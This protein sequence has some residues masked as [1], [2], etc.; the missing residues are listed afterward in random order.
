MCRRSITKSDPDEIRNGFVTELQETSDQLATALA[1]LRF[2]Q[3]AERASQLALDT[4]ITKRGKDI[5]QSDLSLVRITA[6][7]APQRTSELAR[8]NADLEDVC[9]SLR[10]TQFAVW[11]SA[12]ALAALHASLVAARADLKKLPT[13]IA[14]HERFIVMASYWV[15]A[16]N[17]DI[18]SYLM[19][20]VSGYVSERLA[21][22]L[23]ALAAGEVRSELSIETVRGRERPT[24]SSVW[25]WGAND[26]TGSSSG[27]D[28]RVDLAMFAALQDLAEY[29]NAR[30]K[31]PVRVIDEPSDA[32]DMR[33]QEALA[34]WVREEASTRH[35]TLCITH[36]ENFAAML[37]PNH[38]WT[39]ILDNDGSHVEID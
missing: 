2:S 18:R 17:R 15:D 22:H 14:K 32:L 38:I 9:T 25:D 26:Y 4:W 33:G 29:R 16:F 1:N 10:N 36:N 20:A 23:R 5:T 7:Y 3:D 21:H 28:R 27:Q 24:L 39:V 30:S 12:H 34:Q 19:Q 11:D 37:E 35:T 31:F 6:G 13:Q 8:V